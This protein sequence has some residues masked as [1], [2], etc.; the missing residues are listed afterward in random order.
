MCTIIALIL[1]FQAGMNHSAMALDIPELRE[2]SQ[3]VQ[4]A[5]QER[6]LMRRYSGLVRARNPVRLAPESAKQFE[7][8]SSNDNLSNS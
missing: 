5:N 2:D 8:H 1:M 6:E 4:A 7:N 3:A